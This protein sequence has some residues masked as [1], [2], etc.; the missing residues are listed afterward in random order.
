MFI[1]F[2][3]DIF[4]VKPDIP[5]ALNVS[6]LSNSAVVTWKIPENVK[7]L[8]LGECSTEVYTEYIYRVY[9]I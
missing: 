2:C 5:T 8:Q 4:L 1:V 6:I 3:L 9:Q 7:D